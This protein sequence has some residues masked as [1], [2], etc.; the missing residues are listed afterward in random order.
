MLRNGRWCWG[1]GETLSWLPVY[2]N[3]G[4]HSAHDAYGMGD[5]VAVEGGYRRSL[6]AANPHDPMDAHGARWWEEVWPDGD[7]WTTENPEGEVIEDC[8]RNHTYWPPA[9]VQHKGQ[10]WDLTHTH[11]SPGWEPGDPAM[12]AVWKARTT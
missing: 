2:R 11:A 8:D 9:A 7:G 6:L 12:H 4:T 5:V 3:T 1:L 10:V